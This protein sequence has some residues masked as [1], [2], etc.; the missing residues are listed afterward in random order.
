MGTVT[1]IEQ[2]EQI[3]RELRELDLKNSPCPVDRRRAE[4]EAEAR[5]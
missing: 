3:R 5:A 4:K 2:V 1:A